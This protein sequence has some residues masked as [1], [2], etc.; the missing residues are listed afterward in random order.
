[1]T[2]VNGYADLQT[3]KARLDIEPS[4]SADDALLESVI[5]AV[6]RWIDDYC[7]RRFYAATETR[8]YTAE[9]EDLLVTDDLLTL[10]TLQTDPTGDRSYSETWA[11]T[12]YDLEPVNAALDGFPYQTITLTPTSTRYFP[13]GVKKGVKIAGSFGF[14]TAA[15]EAVIQ[16]CLIQSA[17]VARRKDA[18]Y[19]SSGN[20]AMGQINIQIGKQ[21]GSS[22]DPD[23]RLMLA[24]YR[25]PFTVYGV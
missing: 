19:G 16:A 4:D 24:P 10:T 18:I 21:D 14:S 22:L 15:P 13:V 6:S 20:S 12:D 25:R 2:L 11:A 3:L 9:F 1:M 8:T 17:R 5:E 23:V 7:R